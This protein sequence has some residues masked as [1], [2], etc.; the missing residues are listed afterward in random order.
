[1]TNPDPAAIPSA[2]TATALRKASRRITQF[3]DE[4][5]APSG[6][7]ST[8]YAVLSEL[9]R[10]GAQ[11][12]S[13]QELA[14]ALVMDRSALG[15]TLRPLERDGLVALQTDIDDARRRLIALTDQGLARFTVAKPLWALAQRRF[16]RLFGA[17]EAA[18]L[19]ETLLRIA[20]DDRLSM[21][22]EDAP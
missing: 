18:V 6:L 8:Q 20:S 4:A 19:R 21:T 12:P 7:R 5:L 14:D 17:A 15:H 1:M 9:Q 11:A 13:L 22:A 2:C 16:H 3:Y 10:R